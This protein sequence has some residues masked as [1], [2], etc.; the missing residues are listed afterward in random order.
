MVGEPNGLAIRLR[1]T[2]RT[3]TA[4]R[5]GTI[6]RAAGWSRGPRRGHHSELPS[7]GTISITVR[8]RR[9]RLERH[10]TPDPV[11]SGAVKARFQCVQASGRRL[12][13]VWQRTDFHDQLE[14]QC[15]VTT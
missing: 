14:R 15:A 4:V 8:V 2:A 5:T 11:R 7:L 3:G 1:T 9:G 12:A 6:E 10:E 13:G